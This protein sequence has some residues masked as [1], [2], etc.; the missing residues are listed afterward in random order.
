MDLIKKLSSFFSSLKLA[1]LSLLGLFIL[2]FWGT[3]AQVNHG[4]FYTQKLFFQSWFI[5]VPFGAYSIPVFPGGLFWGI[6][7]SLSLI[8]ATVY[9][10]KW[11]IRNSGLILIHLGLII[12]VL[13]SGLTTYLGRESQCMI[14]EGQTS[15][16]SQDR[17]LLELAVI[18]TSQPSEDRVIS[19]PESLLKPGNRIPLSQLGL[20]LQV[21]QFFPNVLLELSEDASVHSPYTTGIGRYLTLKSLPVFVQDD[22]QN[23]PALVL[24]LF[25]SG[26]KIDSFLLSTDMVALQRSS[27]ASLPYGFVLRYHRYYFPFSL[28]LLDFSHDVYPGTTIPKNFSSKVRLHDFETGE[29]RE[30]LIYMNHPLRYRGK[31]FYQASFGKNNT[32]SVLQVVENPTWRIPYISCLIISLGL[33]IHFLLMLKHFVS[34]RFK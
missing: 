27:D 33:L 34:R 2:V 19:I 4:I 9:K 30:V 15:F 32:L 22:M 12:L 11:S 20:E 5:F 25:K 16:Y 7:F 29:D 1:S 26:Q 14:E 13:G 31:T 23:N 24:T 3:L 8:S 10:L 17:R 18:D 6:L 21:D 28:T